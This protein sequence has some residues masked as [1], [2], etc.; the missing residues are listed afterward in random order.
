MKC[1]IILYSKTAAVGFK[2]YKFDPHDIHGT[3]IKV[4]A[5]DCPA[6]NF[7]E[8][9]KPELLEKILRKAYF[10][11][12]DENLVNK[13]MLDY[14]DGVRL[15]DK[16]EYYS[17][18]Y[19]RFINST[20]TPED[21]SLSAIYSA[22]LNSRKDMSVEPY[23][24]EKVEQFQS[25][26]QRILQ[27]PN[28]KS[29][30]LKQVHCTKY[31]KRARA[32]YYLEHNERDNNWYYR[33][34]GK[35]E[36]SFEKASEM[37][38]L[39]K[40]NIK[41]EFKER[42]FSGVVVK[43]E[44][45]PFSTLLGVECFDPRYLNEWFDDFKPVKKDGF[46]IPV[47]TVFYQNGRKR[48]VPLSCIKEY[49]GFTNGANVEHVIKNINAVENFG[50][51]NQI[52]EKED[53]SI[54]IE[55]TFLYLDFGFNLQKA[56]NKLILD[57]ANRMSRWS[58]ETGDAFIKISDE[59]YQSVLGMMKKQIKNEC[60]FEPKLAYGE[61]NCDRLVN[62]ANSPF[63]P[64][65]C[66]FRGLFKNH[67][68]L[69]R[70]K[71]RYGKEFA[72]PTG[73]WENLAR[74]PDGV[75]KFIK[76]CG[77]P[78]TP[79]INKIFLS[80]HRRFANLL[81]IWKAGF[82]DE[83]AIDLLMNADEK[84]IF[85]TIIF[86]RAFFYN[87]VKNDKKQT[88]FEFDSEV[89][90]FKNIQFLFNHYDEMT[91]AKLTSELAR[92]CQ[93]GS[94]AMDALEYMINL[95]QENNLSEQIIKKIGREGFTRYNHDMLMRVFRQ[96]HPEK[97]ESFENFPIAYSPEEKQLEWEKDGYK[98]CLPEDTNRLVDI[99]Y[100]MNICVGHLYRE[101]AAQKQCDIV[102]A[103]K[104]DEYEL[105]VELRKTSAN[106]FE[107]VQ[108]SAFSNREPKGKLL[109]AFNSWRAAKN[110]G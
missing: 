99:G 26:I 70:A 105:C 110:V 103:I 49:E 43:L 22:F 67:F 93:N 23:P 44:F 10:S 89:N 6:N 109:A 96:A 9:W 19:K 71:E 7:C 36:K 106:R 63:N 39:W 45:I 75:R 47:A 33:Q 21:N 74:C 31:L 48:L 81:G 14:P 59:E 78:Y 25:E 3:P 30:L 69:E 95:A 61:T 85:A 24:I 40:H 107:V 62:F 58:G 84:F 102:Y 38:E 80:G 104:N 42:D 32:K 5:K 51:K 55:N 97:K 29:L 90:F 34:I 35:E 108:K 88:I 50:D 20:W 65:L 92:N 73:V 77:L 41:Y 2:Y 17:A 100:K 1:D 52:S 79:K 86:Q 15:D 18:I 83:R 57:A 28:Y 66:M 37:E 46:T 68:R 76:L 4:W 54:E 53:G 87:S 72:P 27:K 8:E 98:F 64:E 56:N 101:K 91:C 60:S 94:R 82:R 16:D 11:E 12:F 13:W